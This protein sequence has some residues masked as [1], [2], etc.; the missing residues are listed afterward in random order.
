MN[1][2]EMLLGCPLNPEEKLRE[3]I[4]RRHFFRYLQDQKAPSNLA[5]VEVSFYSST[6]LFSSVPSTKADRK[7]F[8]EE[9]ACL[10]RVIFFH[11]IQFGSFSS[12]DE[13]YLPICPKFVPRNGV[14]MLMIVLLNIPVLT[15][16][17]ANLRDIP[18]SRTDTTI[19][20]GGTQQRKRAERPMSLGSVKNC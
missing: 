19:A 2:D 18:P 14:M 3:S 12:L 4:K 17:K 7:L 5:G 1:N 20:P 11:V 13:P 6:L 16:P 8:D 10:P 9:E 15:H